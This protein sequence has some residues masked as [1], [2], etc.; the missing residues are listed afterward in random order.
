MRKHRLTMPRVEKLETESAERRCLV[1]SLKR[2]AGEWLVGRISALV[3][4]ELSAGLVDPLS[5]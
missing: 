5:P 3:E 1:H 4:S 2:E